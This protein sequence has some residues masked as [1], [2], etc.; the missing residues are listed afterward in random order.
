[1]AVPPQ[2]PRP[3]RHRA[4][5]HRTHVLRAPTSIGA[6]DPSARH[7]A[8]RDCARGR[9]RV[10]ARRNDHRRS[11]ALA[12]VPRTHLPPRPRSPQRLRRPCAPH[13]G[14]APTNL[15]GAPRRRAVYTSCAHLL[16][17][18]CLAD[19]CSATSRS[20]G[21]ELGREC[22]RAKFTCS[23][24]LEIKDPAKDRRPR[25]GPKKAGHVWAITKHSRTGPKTAPPTA[26]RLPTSTT[27]TVNKGKTPDQQGFF[28]AV[29]VGFEP[30]DG[31]NHHM[32]SRHAPSAARTR[33][34]RRV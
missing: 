32:F 13:R 4:R 21:A 3:R 34:R 12:L 33:Y 25:K 11:R 19:A 9:M 15:R 14:M 31:V 28:L 8:T 30:T 27:T 18:S 6:R 20:P 1:M 26:A 23:A 17:D 10:G 16:G 22:W 2:H 24:T 29:P 5:A 7:G